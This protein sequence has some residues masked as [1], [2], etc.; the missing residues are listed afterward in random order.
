MRGAL[1]VHP[2]ITKRIGSAKTTI[3]RPPLHSVDCLGAHAYLR[4]KEQQSMYVAVT[5]ADATKSAKLRWTWPFFVWLQ[6][7]AQH[8]P[9]QCTPCDLQLGA[10]CLGGHHINVLSCPTNFNQGVGEPPSPAPLLHKHQP[11]GSNERGLTAEGLLPCRR[12]T[13]SV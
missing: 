11:K 8:T 1:G 7:L 12:N 9:T 3:N 10:R 13:Q 5:G 2:F 6:I 4:S